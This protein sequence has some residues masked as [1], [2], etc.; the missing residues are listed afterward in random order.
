MGFGMTLTGIGAIILG[1]QL[2]QRLTRRTF[3]RISAEL[4]SC[5]LGV[6]LYFFSLNVLLRMDVNPIYLK[7]ILGLLLILFLRAAVK[8]YSAGIPS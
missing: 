7:M 6:L 4:F 3:F 8:P 5:L 1:Q 2:L